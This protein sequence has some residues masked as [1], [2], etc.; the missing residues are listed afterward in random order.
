MLKHWHIQ[1]FFC[2]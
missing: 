1:Y 2:K